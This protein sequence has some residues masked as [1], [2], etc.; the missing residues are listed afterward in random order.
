[1]EDSEME[2]GCSYLLCQGMYLIGPK[3]KKKSS[4]PSIVEQYLFRYLESRMGIQSGSSILS[5]QEP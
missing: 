3:Y 5:S 1:M 2:L 4:K